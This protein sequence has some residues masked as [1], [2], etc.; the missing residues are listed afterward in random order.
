MEAASPAVAFD[1]AQNDVLVADA[2]ALRFALHLAVESLVGLYSPASA[3]HGPHAGNSHGLSEPMRHEPRAFQA[4]AQ[5]AVKLVAANALLA[6]GHQDHRLQPNPHGD[7][8]GLEYG[9]DLHG[10]GLAAL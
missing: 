7:M 4:H 5:D 3:A 8:A 9:P 6:A 1:Q 2:L 10:E